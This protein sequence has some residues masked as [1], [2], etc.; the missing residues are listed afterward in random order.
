M[1]DLQLAS[2]S[3][4]E[5]RLLNDNIEFAIR[6]AIRERTAQKSPTVG[7]VARAVERV[8]LE[9]ERDAWIAARRSSKAVSMT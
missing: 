8:D 1:N 3:L 6:A 9:R 5:L 7:P 4:S 2:L